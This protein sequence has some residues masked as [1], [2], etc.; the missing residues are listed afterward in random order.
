[1]TGDHLI[2]IAVFHYFHHPFLG[3]SIFGNTH[4]NHKPKTQRAF[5]GDSHHF[6]A[7]DLFSI[8]LGVSPTKG[9]KGFCWLRKKTTS[10]ARGTGCPRPTWQPSPFRTATRWR[11]GPG[12]GTG[13]GRTGK[14][15]CQWIFLGGK[16]MGSCESL[17]FPSWCKNYHLLFLGVNYGELPHSFNTQVS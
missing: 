9:P 8:P 5:F 2:S 13:S 3:T 10:T 15:N 7:H 14:T 11:F 16:R 6:M 12:T 1:M 4:I 17:F